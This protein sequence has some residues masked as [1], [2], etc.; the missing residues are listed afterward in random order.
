MANKNKESNKSQKK[1]KAAKVGNRPH[2][3]RQRE[4]ALKQVIP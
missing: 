4:G 3:Q 2:E 1:Q